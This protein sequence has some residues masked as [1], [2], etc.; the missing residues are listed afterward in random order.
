[1]TMKEDSD[2]VARELLEH[3]R[4]FVYENTD[5]LGDD[6]VTEGA[7]IQHM[8]ESHGTHPAMVQLGLTALHTANVLRKIGNTEW[9]INPA[10]VGESSDDDHRHADF[11][12][13][14]KERL[15]ENRDEFKKG[16]IEGFEETVE[17]Y[18]DG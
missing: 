5:P 15:E 16:L 14:Y 3:I 4:D 12:E 13:S 8:I 7:I 10:R 17:R 2:E 1:M 11:T 18:D 9:L 6:T